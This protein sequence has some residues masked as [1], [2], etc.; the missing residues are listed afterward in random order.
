MKNN[1]QWT[2]EQSTYQLFMMNWH[3]IKENLPVAEYA[4]KDVRVAMDQS[5]AFFS[6]VF[7]S[8]KNLMA[9]ILDEFYPLY[10]DHVWVR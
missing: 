4:Q 5:P 7:F 6:L 8:Y 2:Y 3:P 10:I 1:G 9:I